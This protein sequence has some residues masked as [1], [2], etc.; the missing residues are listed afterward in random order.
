MGCNRL[1]LN[2]DKT[3]ANLD[4]NAPASWRRSINRRALFTALLRFSGFQFSEEAVVNLGVVR[5]IRAI[6]FENVRKGERYPQL[7]NSIFTSFFQLACKFG[8]SEVVSLT[9]L[10]QQR[11]CVNAFVN[12]CLDY[13]NS[14]LLRRQNEG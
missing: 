4:G 14:L 8:Q 13:C 2:V 12:S 6:S 11:H 7:R 5:N 3:Q 1:R 9:S 10:I